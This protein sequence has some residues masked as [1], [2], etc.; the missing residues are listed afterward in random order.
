MPAEDSFSESNLSAKKRFSY[1]VMGVG[2]R[3]KLISGISISPNHSVLETTLFPEDFDQTL[4]CHP[5]PDNVLGDSIYGCRRIT[6][7]VLENNVTPYFLP[8]SNVTF[9]SKGARGWHYMQYLLS[10]RSL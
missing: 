1:A 2:V 6:D 7:V 5:N 10:G 3:Y 8:R 9:K 4:C